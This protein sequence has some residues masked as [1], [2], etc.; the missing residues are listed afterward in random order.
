VSFKGLRCP[1]ATSIADV[2]E[3]QLRPIIR[4]ELNGPDAEAVVQIG[5]NLS[6]VR[7]SDEAESGLWRVLLRSVTS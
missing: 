3:A 4:D 5:T 7:L 6:M 2:P 1:T